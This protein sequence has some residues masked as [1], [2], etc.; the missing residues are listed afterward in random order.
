MNYSYF[1]LMGVLVL[2]LDIFAI[3]SVLGGG[4]SGERKALWTLVILVLPFLGMILYFAFGRDRQ[5][6]KLIH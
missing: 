1:S 4:S 6:A 3:V 2:L 5:D